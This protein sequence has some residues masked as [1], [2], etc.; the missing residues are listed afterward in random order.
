MRNTYEHQRVSIRRQDPNNYSD[1]ET[2]ALSNP[3][4]HGHNLYSLKPV[5]LKLSGVSILLLEV[6]RKY[7]IHIWQHSVTETLF[8]R[9]R[10]VD[11]P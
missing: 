11:D 2:R 6:K 4:P 7:N 8:V 1:T 9:K 10:F 5:Q 3:D